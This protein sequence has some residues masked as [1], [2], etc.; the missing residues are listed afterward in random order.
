MFYE[1]F[2][3]GDPSRASNAK[4]PTALKSNIDRVGRSA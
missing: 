4:F 3:L 1:N 2:G